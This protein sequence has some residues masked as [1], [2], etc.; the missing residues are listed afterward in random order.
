MVTLANLR[1]NAERRRK[2]EVHYP[3]AISLLVATGLGLLVPASTLDQLYSNEILSS[4]ITISGI[5]FGF[6][7]TMLTLL[8]QTKNKAMELLV[9]NNRLK[10]L[11][12]YNKWAVYFA[13]ILTILAFILQILN[14]V[15]YVCNLPF[16]A[17]D[18]VRICWLLII[19]MTLLY[20]YRYLDIF[21]TILSRD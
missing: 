13:G 2:T 15:D 11:I 21:Y 10:E 8:L 1:K 20:T 12:N 16:I 5:L 18:A 14:R 3:W 17:I 7:L 4:I 6:L 19:L 9:K